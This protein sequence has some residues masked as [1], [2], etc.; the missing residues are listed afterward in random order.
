MGYL[1]FLCNNTK[2]STQFFFEFSR[3]IN[4]NVRVTINVVTVDGFK[5]P[6]DDVNEKSKNGPKF[7]LYISTVNIEFLILI[8]IQT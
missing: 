4:K 5:F 7:M 2:V 8:L 3:K 6:P 1:I